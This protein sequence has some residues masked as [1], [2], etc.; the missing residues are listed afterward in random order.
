MF[1]ISLVSMHPKDFPKS[2]QW[3][4]MILCLMGVLIYFSC[5]FSYYLAL[6]YVILRIFSSRQFYFV[7]NSHGKVIY[8]STQVRCPL[9]R[10]SVVS[11][12]ESQ[13]HLLV[14]VAIMCLLLFWIVCLISWTSKPSFRVGMLFV[15]YLLPFFKCKIL[16]TSGRYTD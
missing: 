1:L 9:G 4:Q 11:S 10:V 14:S 12:Q 16:I 15:L 3:T 8:F 13:L 5:P 6:A 7:Q 2:Y